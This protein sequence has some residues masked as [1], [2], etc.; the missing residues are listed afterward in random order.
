MK[1][2]L[3]VLFVLLMLVVTIGVYYLTWTPSTKGISEKARIAVERSESCTHPN[4]DFSHVIHFPK[5][6]KKDYTG[7]PGKYP[8]TC[9]NTVSSFYSPEAN[10]AQCNYFV[11]HLKKLGFKET[12]DP[13]PGDIV[14]FFKA[15]NDA[16]HTGLYVGNL[17]F[18]PMMNHSDGGKKPHNYQK[19]FPL[20]LFTIGAKGYVEY[21]YYTCVK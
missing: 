14:V 18:G 13:K 6:W 12:S 2:F 21:K 16:R 7:T 4:N 8:Q 17:L 10:W 20:K 19:H 1:K 3:K 9:M 11:N 15:N 5:G